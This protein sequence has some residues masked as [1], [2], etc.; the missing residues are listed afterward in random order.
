[1]HGQGRK[2][3]SFSLPAL[4]SPPFDPRTISNLMLDEADR[5]QRPITNL[6]LQKLLYFAHGIH[7]IETKQALVTG[8]FEAW[9]YGPVHPVSYRAFKTSGAHPISFR[10]NA[11]DPF[12]DEEIPLGRCDDAEALLR[13]RRVVRTYAG[14]TPGRL[15]ELAHAQNAP[16]HFI[17][18]KARTGI[19]I[20]LRIPDDVILDRFKFHK[21]TVNERPKKGEPR[22]D[23]PIVA[24]RTRERGT[25]VRD[26]AVDR[27]SSHPK[28]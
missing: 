2:V 16:W 3:M 20:G 14:M 21:V 19:T 6:A 23:R 27:T 26:R 24:S 11:R 22:E 9:H 28:G 17:V 18:D 8:F 1:M 13:V 15:V 10:A 5:I 7:L 12:T 4:S 25:A